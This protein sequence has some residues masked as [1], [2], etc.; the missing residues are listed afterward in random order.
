MKETKSKPNV[1]IRID[2]EVLHKAKVA[3]VTSKMT[4][5]TWLEEAIREKIERSG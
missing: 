5:G 3:A 1:S 4:V 2:P